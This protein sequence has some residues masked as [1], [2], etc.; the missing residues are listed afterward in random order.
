MNILFV[1]FVSLSQYPSL[2]SSEQE[3]RSL[4]NGAYACPAVG[5]PPKTVP[6]NT[7]VSLIPSNTG[8]I[9]T[10]S[11]IASD[12]SY[13]PV[14]RSYDGFE[15]ESVAG[16]HTSLKFTCSGG[17]CSVTT[18]STESSDQKFVLTTYQHSITKREEVARFFE[19]VTFGTTPDDLYNV[20]IE[21]DLNSFYSDWVYN[22][23]Y[24]TPETLHR[25]WWRSHTS[26]IYERPGKEG[27]QVHPCNVGSRWRRRAFSQLDRKKDVLITKING[28]YH[29]SIENAVR[30]TVKSIEFRSGDKFKYSGPESYSICV[31]DELFGT[32]GIR[33]KSKCQRFLSGNPFISVDGM[34][35]PQVLNLKNTPTSK[36]KLTEITRDNS[37]A[38]VLVITDQLYL[39]ECNGFSYPYSSDIFVQLPNGDLL[40]HQPT[41]ELRSNTDYSPLWDGGGNAISSSDGKALCTNAPQTFINEEYCHVTQSNVGCSSTR[42]IDGTL[43]LNGSNLK[44]F[45]QKSNKPVYVVSNLR[46]SDDQSVPS[47]CT[48]GTV[49]RWKQIDSC[50][51]N[52]QPQ[53]ASIF[54]PL[55]RTS[56]ALNSKIIDVTYEEEDGCDSLDLNTVE[57]KMRVDGNCYATVH[58]DEGN[59]YDFSK[60]ALVGGDGHPGNKAGYNPIMNFAKNGQYILTFPSGHP[61]SRWNLNKAVLGY[62]GRSEDDVD[63]VDLPNNLKTERVASALGIYVPGEE[64]KGLVVCGSRGETTNRSIESFSFQVTRGGNLDVLSDVEYSQQRKKVWTMIALQA[65]DQLRQRVAW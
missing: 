6:S 17:S 10:L 9:C 7:M 26:S 34:S 43:R 49:S 28:R 24:A 46:L 61:M 30:T 36:Y 60:W 35:N 23:I 48:Y 42:E 27:T 32:F 33:Y 3:M 57:M 5:S 50:T 45:F 25:S 59:V 15:W 16:P 19:Q 2:V 8:E 63:F 55:I 18:P 47:P 56:K 1:L 21:S 54:R 40:I 29:L 58:P 12:G 52:I 44:L 11:R 14:G 13:A 62:V 31:A 38:H 20:D 39:S 65:S 22:Q 51:Q 37:V 4:Q 64:G 41:L 53:T